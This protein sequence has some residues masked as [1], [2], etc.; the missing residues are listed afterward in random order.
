MFLI[1]NHSKSTL[2]NTF[3]T[4]FLKLMNFLTSFENVSFFRFSH[5]GF[6]SVLVLTKTLEHFLIV[7]QLAVGSFRKSYLFLEFGGFYGAVGKERRAGGGCL[8]K[9]RDGGLGC[10]KKNKV[11]RLQNA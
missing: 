9:R 4:L 7:A 8:E 6:Q 1:R 10:L 3:I 2:I 11:K 5:Q